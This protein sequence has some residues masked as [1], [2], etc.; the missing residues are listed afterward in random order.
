MGFDEAAAETATSKADAIAA[1]EAAGGR[2]IFDRPRERKIV[3][4]PQT[5]GHVRF[6]VVSDTHLGHRNQQ[7][8]HLRDFYRQ[9]GEWGA[10]FMLHAG[11]LVDGQNMHRDQQFE[12]FQHGVDAQAKYAIEHLPKL[13]RGTAKSKLQ[14][15]YIIGGNHDGSGWN[16]VGANVLGQ[17]ADNRPDIH[18]LGAPQ[19]VF[20][21]DGL[22]IMLLHPSGGSPYA[23]SYRAQKVVEGFAPDEKPHVLLIGHLHYFCHVSIRNVEAYQLPCFQAQTA[24]M[25]AKGLYPDIG[26]LLFDVEYDDAGPTAITNKFV[27]YS[28]AKKEDW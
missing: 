1:I 14:P 10:E 28:V 20:D 18:F 16:D 7:I 26:G 27:R 9:A 6:G 15:Q 4:D 19:A 22:R 13:G 2:V 24:Y 25:K 11:D 12:L 17:L 23:K 3:L 21:H 8:S 5:A